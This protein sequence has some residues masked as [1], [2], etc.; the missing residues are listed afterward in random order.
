MCRGAVITLEDLP[1]TL[2]HVPAAED[3]FIKVPLGATMEKAEEII[4]R[5]TLAT[6]NGNQSRAAEIL[7]IGRKTLHRKLADE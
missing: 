3:G 1:P 5:E 2:H 4:I 7:G 6:C